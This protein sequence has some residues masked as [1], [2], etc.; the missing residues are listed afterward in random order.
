MATATLVDLEKELIELATSV[1]EFKNKGYS[2]Y[3]LDDLERMATN[4]S[5]VLPIVGVGYDGAERAGNQVEKAAP[6]VRGAAFVT[7]QFVIVIAVSYASAG[8]DDN[9]QS[10]MLLL[11]A[12]R[13]KIIGHKSANTR[14]WNFIGERPEPSESGDGV[15]F[16]SQVWQT[17]VPLLGNQS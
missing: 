4:E 13:E 8:Q 2:I 15:I 14:G 11:G 3:S 6:G 12:L 1:D 9:K 10:A 17:S 16:Y 5:S 7:I